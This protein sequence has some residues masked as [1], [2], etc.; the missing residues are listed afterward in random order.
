MSEG[1]ELPDRLPVLGGA[2]E[3]IAAAAA[4]ALVWGVA[5]PWLAGPAWPAIIV[6]VLAC[7]RH[8]N[9]AIAGLLP[10]ALASDVLAGAPIGWHLGAL[11]VGLLLAQWVDVRGERGRVGHGVFMATMVLGWALWEGGAAVWAGGAWSLAPIARVVVLSVLA[12]GLLSAV[13]IGVGALRDS[14]TKARERRLAA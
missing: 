12:V 6:G 1:V 13:M 8:P 14:I 11:G 5:G 3:G 9:R 10:V 4:L 7:D 2:V